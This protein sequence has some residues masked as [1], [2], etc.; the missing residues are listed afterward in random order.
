MLSPFS[1]IEGG[2]FVHAVSQ[3][4]LITS[5]SAPW[6]VRQAHSSLVK[7]GLDVSDVLPLAPNKT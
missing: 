6:L 4:I 1:P 3:W 5:S 2:I 7:L